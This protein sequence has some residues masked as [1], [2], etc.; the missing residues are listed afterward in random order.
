MIRRI[1]FRVFAAMFGLS[2][3]SI[4][5]LGY[6]Y[7]IQ[8]ER[9]ILEVMQTQARTVARS[10]E[11]VSA[12]AMVMNDQGMILENN[13]NILKKSPN[14]LYIVIAPKHG[15]TVVSTKKG[16]RV[17]RLPEALETLQ[18]ER[19]SYTIFNSPLI[20]GTEVFH[21]VYP[22]NFNG[23]DWGW[24]HLGFSV[25]QIE[26]MKKQLFRKIFIA[27][28][29]VLLL[30][31]LGSYLFSKWLT[32]PII[33]LNDAAKKV[34]GGKLDTQIETDRRDETGEL[35]EN[36]NMMIHKL[37]DNQKQLQSANKLLE[38]R[39]KARTKDLQ[40]LNEELEN[41]VRTEVR[42]SREKDRMLIQQ[43]RL[44]AMGEMIGN[45]A[46]QWRQPLNALGLVLQNIQLAYETGRMDREYL[47][48]ATL[49]GMRL[50]ESMSHTIDDFRNFFKPN[51]SK[52]MFSVSDA[53]NAALE[54]VDSSFRNHDISVETDVR[55]DLKANGY[56]SEFSQVLL[57]VLNN[58]KDALIENGVKNR[59]IGIKAFAK[60]ENI[61]IE[62]EDNAGGIEN[63]IIEKIFDP[64]FT[65]KDEGKGTGLGLYMSKMIMQ[66]SMH[67][68]I[69]AQNTPAGAKFVI[70]IPGHTEQK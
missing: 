6:F 5:L 22:L 15:E 58:A 28:W 2:L 70:T 18:K 54:L 10:I 34:A 8:Q 4:L 1:F 45:I 24:L 57:N 53:I 44:A 65:T 67:G 41:L 27:V 42:K 68:Q 62:I 29:F 25:H 66:R 59:K 40:K 31:V 12:D 23:F 52:E 63:E 38:E 64:Y 19:A 30:T 56:P 55:E 46:H 21:Y 49:K 51:K 36:F 47:D 69:D 39:V 35:I 9:L 7:K 3:V 11:L 43:S 16:W 48:K 50:I 17:E 33:Q 13:L 60:E 26:V 32:K 37:S 61:V 14:I 20:G